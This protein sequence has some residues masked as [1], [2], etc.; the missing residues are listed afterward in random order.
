MELFPLDERG[1][2]QLATDMTWVLGAGWS[3]TDLADEHHSKAY[4]RLESDTSE[5]VGLGPGAL[6]NKSKAFSLAALGAAHATH[7]GQRHAAYVMRLTPNAV[8]LCGVLDGLPAIGYD[9][10]GP[11]TQAVLP[12]LARFLRDA[13]PA[14][15]SVYTNLEDVPGDPIATS[16]SDLLALLDVKDVA[17]RVRVRPVS[18]S[19]L[20]SGIAIS[21]ALSAAIWLGWQWWQQHEQE[22]RIRIAAAHQKPPQQVYEESLPTAFSKAGWLPSETNAVLGQVAK[23]PLERAGWKVEKFVCSIGEGGCLFSW[24]R[25]LPSANV[26]DFVAATPGGTKTLE[27][28]MD[29]ISEHV[30]IQATPIRPIPMRALR[31]VDAFLVGPIST[32][33]RMTATGN[34]QIALRAPIPFATTDASI[35][36]VLQG[37]IT[38]S[39][40]LY[41]LPL[42][43]AVD[44]RDISV[45]SIEVS[46]GAHPAFRAEVNYYAAGRKS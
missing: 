33:Q 38:L 9:R 13:E 39:G 25:D 27:L 32:W 22:E 31:S 26:G 36:A 37:A 45:A 6:G 46:V 44:G 10:S 41:L 11:D 21:I 12:V 18:G 14:Q 35:Q 28:A 29:R 16:L 5:V 1:Q 30:R 4:V 15:V 20:M 19:H 2:R 40:D 23:R 8:A 7:T 42:V 43:L 24:V 17:A 34:A 3:V